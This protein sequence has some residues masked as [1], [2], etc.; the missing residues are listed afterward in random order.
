MT[1]KQSAEQSVSHRR[2]RGILRE[3]KT[4]RSAVPQVSLAETVV[5]LEARVPQ[6]NAEAC[7]EA[8]AALARLNAA[9]ATRHSSLSTEERRAEPEASLDLIDAKAA[10]RR[11][12]VSLPTLYRLARGGELPTVRIGRDLIRFSP[13]AL[14]EFVGGRAGTNSRSSV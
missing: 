7:L 3:P 11:L 12:G 13:A 8:I 10:A 1:R 14:A 9:L 6:L 2:G 4:L 5:E